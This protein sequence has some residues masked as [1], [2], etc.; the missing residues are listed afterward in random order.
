MRNGHSKHCVFVAEADLSGLDPVTTTAYITRNHSCPIDDTLFGTD[1]SLRI[2]PQMA[3]RTTV[4]NDG[5]RCSFTLRDGPAWHDG[6]PAVSEDCV[7]RVKRR[8][9]RIRFGQLL[10]AHTKKIAP[11]DRKT[12]ALKLAEH[13]GLVFESLAGVRALFTMRARIASTPVDEQIGSLALALSYA[14][15][16]NGSRARRSCTCAIRPQVPRDEPPCRSSGGK[17]PYLDMC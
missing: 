1:E 14:R 3:D 4:S 6:Q 2:K 17:K 8:A 16:T 13:F 5:M 11:I 15:R 7:E 10:M 9:E 12:F